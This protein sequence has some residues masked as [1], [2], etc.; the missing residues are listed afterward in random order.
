MNKI[1]SICLM[2]ILSVSQVKSES[3][4]SVK[5]YIDKDSG[6]W[7]YKTNDHASLLKAKNA[8]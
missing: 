1:F 3:A 2:S 7:A 4:Y 5:V 8:G 6:G